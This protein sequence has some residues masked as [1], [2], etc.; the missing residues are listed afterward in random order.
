M[1]RLA[2]VSDWWSSSDGGSGGDGRDG[3]WVLRLTAEK[4]T[5]NDRLCLRKLKHLRDCIPVCQR[6]GF[7]LT[8]ISPGNLAMTTFFGYRRFNIQSDNRENIQIDTERVYEQR[9]SICWDIER[10]EEE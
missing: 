8:F 5:H 2:A 7:Y 10:N 4:L 1:S 9:F 3:S 6:F